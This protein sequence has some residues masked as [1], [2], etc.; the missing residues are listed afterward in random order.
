MFNLPN[1][2][3]WLSNER[4]SETCGRLFDLGLWLAF[5]V[6]LIFASLYKSMLKANQLQPPRLHDEY[7]V[8]L[9]PALVIM[10]VALLSFAMRFRKIPIGDGRDALS[11]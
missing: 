11:H 9:V 4:R 1:R 7:W 3:Y 8:P 5:A 10:G 2:D 6:T